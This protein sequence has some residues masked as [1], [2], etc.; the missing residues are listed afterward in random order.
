MMHCT[1][2][3]RS[4]MTYAFNDD[5][6]AGRALSFSAELDHP[7]SPER[8]LGGHLMDDEMCAKMEVFKE[9]AACTNAEFLQLRLVPFWKCEPHTAD[10]CIDVFHDNDDFV[11]RGTAMCGA[12]GKLVDSLWA[13]H[14]HR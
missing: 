4:Y 11:R 10:P 12:C 7:G 6:G 1:P 5:A 8:R 13:P 9:E 3:G 14:D 2:C